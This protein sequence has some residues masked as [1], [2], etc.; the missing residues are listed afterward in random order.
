MYRFQITLGSKRCG[1][2]LTISRAQSFPR[3][4]LIVAL[5]SN[6]GRPTLLALALVGWADITDKVSPQTRFN[7]RILMQGNVKGG[8]LHGNCFSKRI[9]AGK[10]KMPS[11][12]RQR[13][14]LKRLYGLH[15]N[16]ERWK[17]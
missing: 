5:Y 2:G 12:P 14:R 6:T 1:E 15:A 7:N 16:W 10:L 4:R 13:V 17:G 11:R 3:S 8:L 9:G